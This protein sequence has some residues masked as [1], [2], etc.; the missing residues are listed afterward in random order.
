MATADTVLFVKTEIK[1]WDVSGSEPLALNEDEDKVLLEQELET[2]ITRSS[3]ILGDDLLVIDR[4][5][6]IEGVG[7]LDLLCLDADGQFVIVELKRDLA[8]RVAVAQALDYAAW[9]NSVSLDVLKKTPLNFS[10]NRSKTRLV[11]R[12]SVMNLTSKSLIPRTTV[13]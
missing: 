9:I 13:F 10:S 6:S 3:A 12:N 8:P 4:Q 5:R 11:N 1:A 7:R 2:W